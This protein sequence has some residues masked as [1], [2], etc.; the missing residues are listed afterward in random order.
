MHAHDVPGQSG[1]GQKRLCLGTQQQDVEHIPRCTAR[2]L[3]NKATGQQRTDRCAKITPGFTLPK[4][5]QD[6]APNHIT[7]LQDIK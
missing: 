3:K 6:N 2:T 4:Y 1:F 7:D 5:L